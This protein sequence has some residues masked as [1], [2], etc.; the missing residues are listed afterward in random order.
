VEYSRHRTE[1][2]LSSANLDGQQTYEVYFRISKEVDCIEVTL[3]THI[4]VDDF[5]DRHRVIRTYYLVERLISIRSLPGEE[6]VESTI[7]AR[8]YDIQWDTTRTVD[9]CTREDT[10]LLKLHPSH[11]YRIRF[12][13]FH[14]DSFTTFITIKSDCEITFYEKR[15]EPLERT[16]E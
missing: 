4:P 16:V 10:P 3:L 12:T 5:T 11:L 8:N 13:P 1:F 14:E 7:M 9:I 6:K 2:T 15:P